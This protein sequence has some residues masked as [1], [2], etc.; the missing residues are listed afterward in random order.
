[1]TGLSRLSVFNPL[2]TVRILQN[3]PLDNTYSD[4]IDFKGTGSVT[5]E[6]YFSSKTKYFI[7]NVTVINVSNNTFTAPYAADLL[8]DCNYIMFQNKNFNNK[9]FYAFIT[10]I[11]WLS[12]NS[13]RITYELDVMQTWLTEV[14]IYPSFVDREHTNDDTIGSNLVEESLEQ[15]EYVST[16]DLKVP[17]LNDIAIMITSTVDKSNSS[18]SGSMRGNMYTGVGYF[19]F[20]S[21]EEANSYLDALTDDNK[22]T[23][24]L[25]ITMFPKNF[26]STSSATPKAIEFSMNKPYKTI[27]GYTPKNNKLFTAPYNIL[28]VTNT[29]GNSAEYKYEYSNDSEIKFSLIGETSANPQITLIPLNYRGAAENLT[30]QLVLSGYPQCAWSTDTYRAWLAQNGTVTQIGL[31][32]TGVNAAVG[33]GTSLASGN[34]IGA[35]TTAFSGI[36]S[37][38]T[39][40]ARINEIKTRPPQSQGNQSPGSMLTYGE[41]N[42]HFYTLQISA[43]FARQIDDFFSM[44]GYKVNRVKQPNVTGRK[45]WN[46]VKL[47]EPKIVGSIPFGDIAKIKQIYSNGITRWH[48]PSTALSYTADNSIV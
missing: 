28:S 33:V 1:M 10:D 6:A 4:T 22:S 40:M 41:F 18:V 21:A 17:E 29:V 35:A 32:S 24:V 11:S 23:A 27:S 36:T 3:I 8:Y 38:A 37:I 45:N 25:S 9:W 44:Y 47:L 5:Q 42:Y 14:D 20:E 13:S 16:Q 7:D 19:L 30:E 15:G 43:D 2:G 12:P 46:Y 31:I 26:Y 34:L 48:N 39:T